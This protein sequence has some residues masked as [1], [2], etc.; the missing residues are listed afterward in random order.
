MAQND[1]Y[2][3]EILQDVGLVTRAQVDHARANMTTSS[4]VDSLVHEGVISQEDIAKTL[5]AQNG[6]EFV[7]LGNM[8]VAPDVLGMIPADDAKRYRVMP[9]SMRE[10]ALLM[11]IGDPLDMQTM[12]DLTYKLQR[13]VEFVC[14]TP[15]A[16]RKNLIKY[17]GSAE[18]ASS[19]LMRQMGMDGEYGADVT[20]EGSDGAAME[21]DAPIIKMVSLLL[22]EAYNSRASDIHLEPLET[23]F[24]VRFRVDG[25]LQEMQS[26]PKKLHSAMVSRIKIMTGSMSIA[27]KRLPQDGRIQIKLGQKAIDLRVSTIPTVHGESVVMRILDKTSLLLGLPD[28]GFLSDDQAKFEKQINLPDGI[29]LVTGPT[30]SGKTTTLYGCL[31]YMNKPDRKLI[32][33]EDPVEYQMSGINQ[34]PVNADIGMTFPAALRSMLRQAPNIIMIGE[35][36]DFE[37]A[38]IATN[39]SL[40][41]HLVLSTLHTND[42][43]SAVARLV[44]LG[45][46]PFLVSSSVRAVVAQ[47]LVRRLC[48]KCKVPAEL[49]E[50]EMN[51]LRIE[52]GQLSEAHVMR[53]VGCE[54]CRGRGYKGRMGI[55]EIFLVDDEVRHMINNNAS[56]ITLR[57]RARELGMRTLREDG[58]RKVLAGMT[59]AEEVITTTMTDLD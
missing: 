2:I 40:T 37:T 46:K 25:V 30:G 12:D 49:S 53:A 56:T 32:T 21:N 42:A 4:L 18:E 3:V 54:L 11:A 55:F 8:V 19:D 34:V 35:I 45:I 10:G 58:V 47:R 14:A 20:V 7:D 5:A 44:D 50:Y 15:D 16:I 28:L 27:E 43:P 22:V 57:Q 52:P 17:F 38:S 23:K 39:A 41:G 36:R 51:M 31:N 33:V 24:R 6:M 48:P 1:D 26:P 13:E 29:I 9:L 59:T